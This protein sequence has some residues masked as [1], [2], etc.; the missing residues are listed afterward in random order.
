MS[1]VCRH[2][3]SV[4]ATAAV[5]G[6]LTGSVLLAGDEEPCLGTYMAAQ[7]SFAL[8]DISLTTSSLKLLHGSE[9]PKLKRLLEWRLASAIHSASDAI[10]HHPVMEPVSL[11]N[12]VP[13]WKDTVHRARAYVTEHHL[14]DSLFL[15]GDRGLKPSK[16]LD[17][18][19][20][21]LEMQPDSTKAH[22]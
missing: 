14:D 1:E 20:T 2:A 3:T 15:K 11:P 4:L 12:L 6:F 16:D 19:T 10:G 17:T 9:D 8:L 5:A 18:T 22:R 21:W 7:V 13:N